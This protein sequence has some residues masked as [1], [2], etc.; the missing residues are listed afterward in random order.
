VAFT[1]SASSDNLGI[2]SFSWR[3]VAG[4]E[5]ILLSGETAQYTFDDVG[6]YEVVLEVVDTAGNSDED[7]LLVRISPE[8]DLDN[9]GLQDDWEEDNFGD[10][11]ESGV[12][13]PDEDR[14]LNIQEEDAGT[15]PTDSDTDGDG[16][17]DGLDPEPLIPQVEKG[18]E[19]WDYWWVLV[20]MAAVVI[21]FLAF[22]VLRRPPE[23]IGESEEA[24]ADES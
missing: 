21:A 15:D 10:L 4:D 1:A 13:D 19:L 12:D 8:G 23:Q 11:S 16:L 14:F 3:F 7:V 9:D 24:E 18:E 5:E 6:T 2:H 22:L 20:L 17:V